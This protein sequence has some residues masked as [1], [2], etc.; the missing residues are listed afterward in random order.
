MPSRVRPAVMAA[1]LAV[2]QAAVPAVEEDAG[3][4]TIAVDPATNSL[5]VMGSETLTK[6]IA[7]LAQSLQTQIPQEPVQA[8]IVRMPQ[9]VDASPI[10][11]IVRSTVQQMGRASATNQEG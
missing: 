4:I 9:G 2:G 10:A 6:R 8:N 7:D 3:E 1:M 5:V 11:D